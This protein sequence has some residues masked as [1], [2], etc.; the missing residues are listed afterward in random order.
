MS[1]AKTELRKADGLSES[2]QKALDL[3]LEYIQLQHMCLVSGASDSRF[4]CANSWVVG[5]C[6]QFPHA[7]QLERRARLLQHPE[8]RVELEP[9]SLY[10]VGRLGSNHA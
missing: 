4:N 10:L 9:S 1:P 2:L 5:L 7:G 6:R 8:G 3:E